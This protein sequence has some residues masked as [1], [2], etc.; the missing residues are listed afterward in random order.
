MMMLLLL[1]KALEFQL[2]LRGKR[3]LGVAL[4]SS[5]FV[6]SY[7][8]AKIST[9]VQELQL[10]AL[11]ILMLHMQV[12]IGKCNF[13]MR[14]IPNTEDFL[15]PLEA[16]IQ[17]KFLPNLTG[18]PLFNDD[19]RRLFA[20]PP[21]WGGLD[22]DNP[23]EHSSYQFSAS[24]EITSPLLRLILQQSSIYTAEVTFEQFEA[25]HHVVSDHCQ[26]IVNLQESLLPSLSSS[27]Q[28]SVGLSVEMGSSSWLTALP[29]SEHG[30][31]LHKETF[32]D[33]LCL[34]Y[35]W[36]PPLLPP[37]CVCSEP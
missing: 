37:S 9:W 14:C 22:I 34:K 33:A 32:R 26:D 24:T 13:L 6:D 11:L 27:F 2:L 18:Q 36:R 17:T 10:L 5:S 29:L 19:E 3:H 15:A 30:F 20:L 7:V 35:G 16:I 12:F 25:K 1:F 28:R 4:G 8:E 23:Q 31:I 21:K